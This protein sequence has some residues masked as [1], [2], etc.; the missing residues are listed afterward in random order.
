MGLRS[1]T[2]YAA[3]ACDVSVPRIRSA[4]AFART[5]MNLLDDPDFVFHGLRH[6][7]I[8]NM[9]IGGLSL[10]QLQKLAGHKSIAATMRY[11]HMVASDID[12]KGI[13]IMDEIQA[14]LE[15]D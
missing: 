7:F 4:W 12:E 9:A 3:L 6:A 1:R 14:N 15:T 8:T 5:R 13:N 11:I 10:P 2:V